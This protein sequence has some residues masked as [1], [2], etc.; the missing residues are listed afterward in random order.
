MSYSIYSSSVVQVLR[1]L[2]HLQIWLEKTQA[3]AQEKKIDETVLVNYR[4]FPDMLPLASQVRIACDVSKGAAARLS[5]SDLPK[6]EDNEQTLNELI[7]RTQKVRTFL[8]GFK[9]IQFDGASEKAIE[10]KLPHRT[11]HFVGAD[12][13]NQFVIPN[14]YFHLTTAYAILRHA[15]VP[16]GKM[17]FLGDI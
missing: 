9:E 3:Y 2:G 8:K 7:E 16:L 17:D 11:M 14:I 6:H 10:L 15:G 1:M 4:L 13:V 5:G 12:Y